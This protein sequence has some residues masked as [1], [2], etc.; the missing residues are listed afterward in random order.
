MR[1]IREFYEQLY[2]NKLDNLGEMEKFIGAWQLPK[3]TEKEVENLNRSVKSKE[4]GSVIKKLPVKKN[5]VSDGFTSYFYQ[6]LK[7]LAPIQH[8]YFEKKIKCSN[9]PNFSRGQY[10]HDSKTRQKHQKK[11]LQINIPFKHRCKN[12]Q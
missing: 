1:I 5:P 4:I 6:V 7:E 3:L 2:A 11:K 12:S 8:R 10:Y 9:M